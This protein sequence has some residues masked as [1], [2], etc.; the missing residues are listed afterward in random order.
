MTKK[1]TIILVFYGITRSLQHTY[2]SIFENIIQPARIEANTKTY[3]HF[4]NQKE[5]NNPRTAE[6]GTLNPDEW[7]LL[8]PDVFIIDEI[9]NESENKYIDELS[10]YGNAW[11]DSGES[12]RNIIRQLLSLQRI[13][14]RIQAD[15][16]AD[17]VVFIRPDMLIHT[18]FP[19]ADWLRSIRPNTVAIPYW[20]WSGGL[21]DRLAVCGRQSYGI[22]GERLN[23][24]THYC[25]R[26]KKPLHSER[27]LFFSLKNSTAQICTTDV[28]ATRIRFNGES[29]NE[30]FEHVKFAKRLEAFLL[31]NLW[32]L[33]RLSWKNKFEFKWK[34]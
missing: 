3:C 25:K 10:R 7:R 21:N 28:R 2:Q 9:N 20:Q 4:F 22:V 17:L 12:L 5:I 1:K 31:C 29:A 15:G 16:G 30:S 6:V 34:L 14:R 23:Q 18:K 24:A 27:L 13:T 26:Y 8:K 11:E 33:L 19:F 32:P